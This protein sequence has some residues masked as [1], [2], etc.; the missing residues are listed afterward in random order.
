MAGSGT[1]PNGGRR[2]VKGGGGHPGQVVGGLGKSLLVLNVL[3]DVDIE[4]DLNE[5]RRGNKR[6]RVA[7]GSGLKT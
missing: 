5:I 2:R 6:R 7:V 4:N 1:G 3:K